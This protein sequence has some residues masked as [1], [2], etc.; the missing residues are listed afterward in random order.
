MRGEHRD[1]RYILVEV[2]VGG[3][4]EREVAGALPGRE[5]TE[6]SGPAAAQHGNP[7]RRA[8]T[9]IAP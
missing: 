9:L 2:P 5:G 6:Q 3:D 1:D 7:A 4:G 8:P